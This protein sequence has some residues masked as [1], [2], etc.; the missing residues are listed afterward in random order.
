MD[1]SVDDTIFKTV[2][3]ALHS[4]ALLWIAKVCTSR[5]IV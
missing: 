5:G 1:L 2:A 3:G 4:P